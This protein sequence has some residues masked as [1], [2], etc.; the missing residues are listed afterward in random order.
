MIVHLFDWVNLNENRHTLRFV[1]Q[2]HS[3]SIHFI[4]SFIL[5]VRFALN[6][7]TAHTHKS[8]SLCFI[9][10]TAATI[11][12]K[13]L[14]S[15]HCVST[16]GKKNGFLTTIINVILKTFAVKILRVYFRTITGLSFGFEICYLASSFYTFVFEQIFFVRASSSVSSDKKRYNNVIDGINLKMVHHLRI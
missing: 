4:H 15:F 9:A 13:L 12:V 6:I 2:K 7:S 11:W 16:H 14:F 10:V 3:F 5:K 8:T 1:G